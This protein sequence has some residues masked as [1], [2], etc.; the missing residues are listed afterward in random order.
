MSHTAR[1]GDVLCFLEKGDYKSY[2][3]FYEY[4]VVTEL[5]DSYLLMQRVEKMDDENQFQESTNKSVVG[6]RLKNGTY[7]TGYRVNDDYM[8]CTRIY[9]REAI[10]L[11]EDS[12]CCS[13]YSE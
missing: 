10:T 5:R 13:S 1:V 4:F 6:A 2:P 11:H 3:R 7:K 12:D 8:L 9:S